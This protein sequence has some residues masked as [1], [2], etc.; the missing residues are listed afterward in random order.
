MMPKPPSCCVNAKVNAERWAAKSAER[1]QLKLI[2]SNY[3][4]QVPGRKHFESLFS[5]LLVRSG[6]CRLAFAG[7]W[8]SSVGEFV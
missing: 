1:K 3:L 4:S 8:L 7:A 2:V 6:G 5:R